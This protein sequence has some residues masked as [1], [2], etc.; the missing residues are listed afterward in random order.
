MTPEQ[1]TRE[2]AGTRR[3]GHPRARILVVDDDHDSAD[4]L[5]SLLRT[6]G[7]EVDV[8]HDGLHV[9]PAMQRFAPDAVLLDIDLP[10]RDGF[11]IA[12]KLRSLGMD[13]DTVLIATTGWARQEDRETAE[14]CGFDH[15]LAK[16]L[17]LA[18]LL[19]VLEHTEKES[20]STAPG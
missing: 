9:L 4:M 8:V 12:R 13:R 11:D 1:P 10:G 6:E 17:D 16:P 2:H 3:L 18:R 19:E 14:V 15:F 5:S 7:Y 20:G